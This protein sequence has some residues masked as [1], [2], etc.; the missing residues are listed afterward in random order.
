MEENSKGKVKEQHK[1]SV[2]YRG[3]RRRPWG[4]FAAEIRDSNRQGVRMWLG[5][6]T[7]AEEAAR[8]YDQAA[9]A[10]RGGLAI[11]NFPEDYGL[12]NA[13]SRPHFSSSSS[14][15]PLIKF[16]SPDNDTV[17]NQNQVFEFEYLDD[18]VLEDL[19]ECEEKETTQKRAKR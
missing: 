13:S 19:L 3:V 10:M 14:P 7:T 2:R 5:T 1:S 16:E 8:A 9:Y 12:S 17:T 18:K 11:L 15:L 6:F 4:K